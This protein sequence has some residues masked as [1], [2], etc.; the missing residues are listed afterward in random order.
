MNVPGT[1][2]GNWRWRFTWD[3]LTSE[4]GKL[5]LKTTRKTGGSVGSH[6]EN[7]RIHEKYENGVG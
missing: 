7:Q 1:A 3:Q 6:S 5:L 2:T 4:C